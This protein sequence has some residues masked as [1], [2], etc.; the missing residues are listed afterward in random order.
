MKSHHIIM[1]A[2]AAVTLLASAPA[3]AQNFSGPRVEGRVGI[4]G[5]NISIKD[6]RDFGGRGDFSSGSTA[7][8]LSIGAEVGF[9]IESGQLAFGAYAGADFGENNEPFPDRQLNFETGRNLT[10]GA[11]VGYVVSPNVLLYAKGGY[12][13]A[14]IKPQFFTGAT[15]AQRNAFAEFDRSQDGFHVGGGAEF[16]MRQS[17]YGRIDF[18]HHIY[19]DFDVDANS[20]FSFRRNQLTAAIGFRF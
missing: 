19:D 14:R 10:A 5:T 12:S 16:A 15:T 3:A 17:F 18:A 7:T 2:A 13:N 20:E 1:T 8:D 4:D 9:D 11:R 6:T